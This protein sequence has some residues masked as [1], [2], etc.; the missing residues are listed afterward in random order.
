VV[1][2]VLR[3]FREEGLISTNAG[4]IELLDPDGVAA[5]VG[6]WR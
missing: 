1:A 4:H 5:I 2:R 6:R 3:E